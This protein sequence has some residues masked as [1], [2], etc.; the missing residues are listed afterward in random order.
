MSIIS[1]EFRNSAVGDKEDITDSDS[2]DVAQE[3][4]NLML[5]EI[6]LEFSSERIIG[7]DDRKKFIHQRLLV[8]RVLEK[9][10]E[11][12]DFGGRYASEVLYRA[13][14]RPRR[15]R[16]VPIGESLKSKKKPSGTIGQGIL[17]RSSS[18]R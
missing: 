4:V 15:Y 10:E 6:F 9:G 8:L 1:G 17:T 5:T 7:I 14:V 12:R 11:F 18:W 13:T 2:Y 16:T 3:F